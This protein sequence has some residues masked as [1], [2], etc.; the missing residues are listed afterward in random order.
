MTQISLTDDALVRLLESCDL[1]GVAVQSAPHSWDDGYIQRL[2][3]GTPTLL[4]AFLGADDPEDA[5]ELNLMGRWGV[6]AVVGWNGQDQKARRIGAGAGFD[7]MHR[8]AAAL[9]SAILKEPNGETLSS[10]KVTG[11]DV[12]TDSAV[13]ISNLWI[14]SID[15]MIGLPLPLLEGDACLGPL[16]DF[17]KIRGPISVS[18]PADDIEAA[19]DL[20]Q[21]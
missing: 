5:T 17:L 12:L 19:V 18:E 21:T 16:D 7:L 15:V 4:V 1:P 3:T 20:P 9:H 14:G 8:A 13:D 10:V 6:Y 11:L 2:I